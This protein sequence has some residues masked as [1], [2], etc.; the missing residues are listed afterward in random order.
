MQLGPFDMRDEAIDEAMYAGCY[1]ELE[2]DEL[3]PDW[4]VGVYVIEAR[5]SEYEC[6]E[7]GTVK[8]ACADCREELSGNP[9]WAPWQFRQVRNSEF[10]VHP[11]PYPDDEPHG[12]PL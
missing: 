2:P 5:G 11:H 6:D 3:E 1:E 12:G 9:N 4:R 8:Q 7:C 10:V